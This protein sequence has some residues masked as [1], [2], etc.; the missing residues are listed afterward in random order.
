MRATTAAIIVAAALTAAPA[1][2]Q[3]TAN[4]TVPAN[5]MVSNAAT[6]PPAT[7]VVVTNDVTATAATNTATQ[8]VRRPRDRGAP[9][10]LIGLAG[11][12][13]LLGRWRRSEA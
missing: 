10:G 5:A 9:W 13:G 1:M 2:A 8:P 7:N 6:A 3:N 4:T 11:L 12:L